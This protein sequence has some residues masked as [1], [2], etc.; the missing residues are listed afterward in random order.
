[1]IDK[2]FDMLIQEASKRKGKDLSHNLFYVCCELD[3]KIMEAF[4]ELNPDFYH[5]LPDDPEDMNK[6]NFKE[7]QEEARREHDRSYLR[8]HNE[9]G[10]VPEGKG[11]RNEHL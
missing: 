8:R 11:P 5:W 9:G 10:Q 6:P 7:S 4:E 3:A 1:M 2:I